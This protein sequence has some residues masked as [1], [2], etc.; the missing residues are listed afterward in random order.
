M[1]K[2]TKVLFTWDKI[3]ESLLTMKGT[4]R[5]QEETRLRGSLAVTLILELTAKATLGLED[6]E[7]ATD[8]PDVILAM[9]SFTSEQDPWTIENSVIEASMHLEVALQRDK[10]TMIERVL[11]Q[12]IRPLF[13]R[14][15]NPA[16]TS[17]GR[18]N[19]HPVPSSRFDGSVLDDSTKPWR[20]TDIYATSALSWIV[21]QC[22]VGA[23]DM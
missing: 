8:S 5:A 3:K 2:R 20:N 18:K 4:K 10:W 7:S 6:R 23:D 9:A 22:E 14:A 21:S 19:L 15:K 13:T 1:L 17:E 11:K 12:K 16:I